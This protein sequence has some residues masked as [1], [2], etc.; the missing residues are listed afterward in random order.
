[1]VRCVRLWQY[2][3]L[4]RGSLAVS[5]RPRLI[6]GISPGCVRLRSGWNSPYSSLL[7]NQ[8]NITLM[9]M[10]ESL[11]LQNAGTHEHEHEH[12]VSI[13]AYGA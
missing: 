4:T 10:P 11:N 7:V 1:M 12:H 9:L 5:P 13:E 2:Q 3:H 8:Y 6:F